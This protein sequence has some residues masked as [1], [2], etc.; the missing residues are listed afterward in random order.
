[1]VGECFGERAQSNGKAQCFSGE[2]TQQFKPPSVTFNAAIELVVLPLA[3]KANAIA[4][5]PLG[6]N[7]SK[8]DVE[9]PVVPIALGIVRSH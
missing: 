4:K 5:N 7:N 3:A 9:A 6:G 1:M 8:P 2:F